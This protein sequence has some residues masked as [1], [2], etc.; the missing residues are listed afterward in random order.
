MYGIF[1]DKFQTTTAPHFPIR[2][3]SGMP[4]YMILRFILT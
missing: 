4:S 3:V 1:S 2:A